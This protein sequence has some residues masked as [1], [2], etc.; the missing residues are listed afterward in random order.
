M[1]HYEPPRES[2]IT[3]TAATASSADA[4]SPAAIHY[5]V[6]HLSLDLLSAG[7]SVHIPVFSPTTISSPRT[8]LPYDIESPCPANLFWLILIRSLVWPCPQ[9]RSKTL[10]REDSVPLC[11][12]GMYTMQNVRPEQDLHFGE[13]GLGKERAGDCGAFD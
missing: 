9:L 11:G 6:Y 13:L 4:H 2:E 8:Y 3:R 1:S 7:W 5:P 12:M 10:R